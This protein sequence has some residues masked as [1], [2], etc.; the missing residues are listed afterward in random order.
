MVKNLPWYLEYFYEDIL[1]GKKYYEVR[2]MFSWYG[3]FKNKKIFAI[4]VDDEFYF[5]KN[6]FV[7][8][9]EQFTY[10]RWD[11]TVFL[12]YF[13]VDESILEN[14]E[15]LEKYIESSLED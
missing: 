1:G 4:Y 12:P 3:I 5:R 9:G 15:E 10:K 6:I 14:E 2:K 13:K 7:E 11:K 8:K